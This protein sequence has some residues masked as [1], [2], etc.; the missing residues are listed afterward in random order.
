MICGNEEGTIL[1][2]LESAKDAFGELCLVR[3]IGD[4]QP[5]RTVEQARVWCVGNGKLFH[6]KEYLNSVPLPHVDNFG[7]AR[8]LSFSLATGDWLLWLD[9]DDYLEQIDALR[10]REAV[11]ECPQQINAIYAKYC[12]AKKGG[13][14]LRERLLRAGKS[15]WKNAIHESCAIEGEAFECPQI[16]VYHSDHKAKDVSSASRNLTIL[17]RVLEDAPRHYFYLQAELK[18]VGKKEEALKAA[19]IALA[20]VGDDMPEERYVILL[21]LSELEPDKTREH[22]HEAARLQPHRRDAFAYL[23]QKSLIDGDLSAAASYF[24]LMDALP[25]PDPLP[26]THQGLWH[27]W[28]RDF[29]RARVLRARGQVAL[30][31][32]EHAK[33][34]SDP[35]YAAGWAKYN[36]CGDKGL[37]V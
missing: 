36:A 10:M 33:H 20:M 17:Q 22:L 32:E 24:R 11:K 37:E 30:A 27:G 12:V 28:G 6:F 8:N 16:S 3:A 29:L 23:C 34:L 15:R 19:K 25:L 5:D 1:R 21:N 9:C 2:C 35:D 14:I 26:W 31:D 7:A 18:I 13:E 4:T